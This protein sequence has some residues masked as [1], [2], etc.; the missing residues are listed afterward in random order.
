M[1]AETQLSL[2][3]PHT[4]RVSSPLNPTPP[5][6]PRSPPLEDDLRRRHKRKSIGIGERLQR[7]KASLAWERVKDSDLQVEADDGAGNIAYYYANAPRLPPPRMTFPP[8]G[9]PFPPPGI[10]F[11]PPG[12][13][14]P[15]PGM[16]YDAWAGENID[17]AGDGL[18][19]VDHGWDGGVSVSAHPGDMSR[20]ENSQNAADMDG[21]ESGGAFISNLVENMDTTEDVGYDAD[22]DDGEGGVVLFSEYIEA[23]PRGPILP[24]TVQPETQDTS[25][26]VVGLDTIELD[27]L[28]R[29]PLRE[30]PRLTRSTR[31]IHRPDTWED[32]RLASPGPPTSGPGSPQQ[33]HNG[34]ATPDRAHPHPLPRFPDLGRNLAAAGL[35]R[36]PS[37]HENVAYV[38]VGVAFFYFGVRFHWF[39]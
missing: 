31:T 10:P 14:F 33:V 20:G 13:P 38:V 23:I 17:G 3:Q 39:F 7:I 34:M 5:T 4:P 36:G 25:T 12:I 27:N 11:P 15:Q 6:T 21:Y 2:P 18:P 19:G 37:A 29:A 35:N 9:I 1:S 22:V 28:A 16:F 8:P 30:R 24:D 32:L 26:T